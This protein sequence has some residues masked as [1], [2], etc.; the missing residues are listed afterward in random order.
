MNQPPEL[1]IVLPFHNE[2]AGAARVLRAVAAAAGPVVASYELVAVDDGSTDGTR[3]QLLAC[4]ADLPVR[5]VSLARN[6]GKE[7]ALSAGLDAARGRAIIF[8]DDDMQ[9]PPALIPELVARWRAGSLIVHATKRHRQR[10]PLG[11]RLG[12]H[13]FNALFRRATGLDFRGQSDFKLID[14]TVAAALRR[15][16]ERNRFFRGLV[17]WVGY[18]SST[19]PFDVQPRAV[20]TSKWRP[21][22]LWLYAVRNLVAFSSAPLYWSAAL[23][24]GFM[25]AGGLLGAQTLWNYLAG[26]AVSGFTTVILLLLIITGLGFLQLAVIAVYL[27]AMYNEVKGRPLYVVRSLDEPQPQIAQPGGDLQ[28]LADG[29][30]I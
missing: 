2:A 18:P 29:D 5:I 24:A 1:T 10:E 22:S 11:Y 28:P 20:G 19:V 25:L 27:A 12:A 21:G 17:T 4:A 6:F 14:A 3:D 16:P 26:V 13:A 7:A 30:G 8:M 23:G 15:L 9:H